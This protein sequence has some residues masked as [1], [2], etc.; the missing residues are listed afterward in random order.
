MATIKR[1]VLIESKPQSVRSALKRPVRTV[2]WVRFRAGRIEVAANWRTS[3]MRSTVV[4]GANGSIGITQ[5]GTD[6][7]DARRIWPS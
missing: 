1:F 5:D 4:R 7:G 3:R 6:L 2:T